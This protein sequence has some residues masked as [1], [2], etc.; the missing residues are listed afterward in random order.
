VPAVRAEV[1]AVVPNGDPS[2]RRDTSHRDGCQ[3]HRRKRRGI[4]MEGRPLC[5]PR[6]GRSLALH[7]K[8]RLLGKLIPKPPYFSAIHA[9]PCFRFR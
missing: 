8:D 5:R 9:H 6:P 2:L 7:K 4:I 1:A 3:L